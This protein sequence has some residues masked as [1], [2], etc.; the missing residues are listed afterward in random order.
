MVAA[1]EVVPVTAVAFAED[2]TPGSVAAN[3][4]GTGLVRTFGGKLV[5]L[6]LNLVSTNAINTSSG[7]ITDTTCY[8]VDSDY[9]PSEGVPA[10]WGNGVTSGQATVAV[11]GTVQ[12]RT[13]SGNLSA[14]GAVV[15]SCCYIKA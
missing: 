8:T 1:G 5:Y 11:D 3:F 12:I 14:G 9:R 10:I 15:I 6:F 7:N 2:T 13:S 4:T